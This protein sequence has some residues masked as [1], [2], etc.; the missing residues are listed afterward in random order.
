M[1]PTLSEPISVGLFASGVYEPDT[2][3]E[4]LHHL[5]VSGTFLD[6][7]ANIGAI[8]LPVAAVNPDSQVVC[9]EADRR[10]AAL[11]YGN[12]QMNRRSNI[13]IVQCVAGPE[14]AEIDFYAAPPEHFGMGSVGPQFYAAGEKLRQRKLD[15]VLDELGIDNVDVAKFDIEGAEFG[16]LHGFRRRLTS[17]RPPVIVFEFLHWAETRIPGQAAGSAQQL[18][19]SYGYTL[20]Q[21]FQRRRTRLTQPLTSGSAMIVATPG[22][23]QH[24]ACPH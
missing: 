10:I 17:T 16:A 13:K 6:V 23:S 3:T 14:D 15:D 9:I 7:G 24:P 11:L 20:F 21:L 8:A 12:V 2:I 18:L 1:V 22:D 5:S 19:L 4:V